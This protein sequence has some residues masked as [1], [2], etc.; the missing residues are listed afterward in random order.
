MPGHSWVL[1]LAPT[2]EKFENKL[3]FCERDLHL[4]RKSD[5]TG[6]PRAPVE[7]N[8]LEIQLVKTQHM[9]CRANLNPVHCAPLTLT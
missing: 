9:L 3:S 5:L 2:Q 4:Q 6:K 8:S 1:L 7:G